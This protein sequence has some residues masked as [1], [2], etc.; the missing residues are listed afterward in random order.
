MHNDALKNGEMK[1]ELISEPIEEVKEEQEF[2][3][4]TNLEYDEAVAEDAF[5]EELDLEMID[6]GVSTIN[7]SSFDLI[8]KTKT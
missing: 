3:P 2:S 5:F 8:K 7:M 4:L 1:N 6:E